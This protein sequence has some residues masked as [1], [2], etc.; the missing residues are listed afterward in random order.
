MRKVLTYIL[1]VLV[2]LCPFGAI[3]QP[4]SVS[5]QGVG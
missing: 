2:S 4:D 1:L 3:A 5:L